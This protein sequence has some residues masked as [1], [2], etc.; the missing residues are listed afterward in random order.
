[1]DVAG[2]RWVVTGAAS[3][4]GDAVARDLTARGASVIS[5]DRNAP[6]AEVAQ[7]IAVDLADPATIDSAIAQLEGD[8]DVLANVAGVPGTMPGD[9]VFKVNFLGMRHLT[10]A[11]FERI[12]PGGAI[13]IVSSTAGFGWP[14]RLETIR[15]LLATGSFAEGLE[16]YEAHPQEGNAYNFA[17]E[18]ATVYTLSM[19][20]SVRSKHDLRINAVLPGPV[21]TPILKDFEDS[22]GKDVL[23]GVK[24][25]V[26]R[27]ATRED[28]APA[29]V[30]LG[31]R[32]SRWVNG[33]TVTADG[34]VTGAMAVGAVLAPSS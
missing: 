22:M 19:G 26:G 32:E 23:D 20:P 11:M 16:W 30:F 17:K 9:F 24:R 27:H 5:L 6:A 21:E 8:V 7:H 10:E 25:L 12:K 29:V 33:S 28:I 13:V 34:G 1:M 2:Q 18:A 3:G 14:R 15:G 31:A 4:I